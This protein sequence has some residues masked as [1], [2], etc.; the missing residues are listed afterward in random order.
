MRFLRVAGAGLLLL[1]QAFVP[2]AKAQVQASLVS[3]V[4]AVKPGRPFTVALRLVHEKGWH[5]YWRNP[6]IGIAT[7][8]DWKLPPGWKAGEIHWPAPEVLTDDK[9]NVTGNGYEGDLLLPLVL[10]P[11]SGLQAGGNANV[12][13]TADWLMCRDVCMPGEGPVSLSLPV[14]DEEPAADPEWGAR[15][16]AA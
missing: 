11:P 8:L 6:G 9:G 13:A 2:G 3:S 5:T 14:S 1:I 12:S 16:S 7:T 10:T 4:V 15:I